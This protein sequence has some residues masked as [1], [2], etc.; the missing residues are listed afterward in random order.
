MPEDEFPNVKITIKH[1]YEHFVMLLCLFALY[2][3][4]QVLSAMLLPMYAKVMGI[5]DAEARKKY[6]ELRDRDVTEMQAFFS[7]WG[8]IELS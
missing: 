2:V 1:E 8:E 5:S 7:K 6:Q 4:G 3:R